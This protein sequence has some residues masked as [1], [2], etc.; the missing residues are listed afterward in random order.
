MT[1][2][3]VLIILMC[4]LPLIAFAFKAIFWVSALL[5]LWGII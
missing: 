2:E 1:K 4:L 5:K 3:T